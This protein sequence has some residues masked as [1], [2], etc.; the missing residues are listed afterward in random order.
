[1]TKFKG[2]YGIICLAL[3]SLLATGCPLTET[4]QAAIDDAV[5]TPPEHEAPDTE[6]ANPPENCFGISHYQ[7]KAEITKE[8]DI[9]FM[10]DTSGSL[11]AERR[12]IGDGVDAFV[13]ALPADA[14]V[15][16]AVMMA[17]AGNW[18]GKLYQYRDVGP[19]VLNTKTMNLSDIRTI[20]R[21]RMEKV[22][23][24][25][26][27]DGG[28]VGL[29][30]LSRALDEDRLAEAKNLGFFRDQAALAVVF[31]ADEND[32]CARYP[33]GITP[34]YDPDRKEVPAFNKYCQ[35]L[36]PEKVYLK[37]RD[38]Q[39]GRPLLVS[40]IVYSEESV[41]PASGENEI[42]YGILDIVR[43][44]NGLLVDLAGGRIYEGL[45]RIGSLVTKRLNLVT[46]YSL[47]DKGREIDDSTIRVEVDGQ[48]VPFAFQ[49]EVSEV[50]LTDYAGLENSEVYLQYCLKP[51]E[52]HET[53]PVT[54]TKVKV[55]KITSTSAEVTWTTDL[56]S[57]SQVEITESLTGRRW[58][59]PLDSVGVI[60]HMVQ[61][62]GL[63]SDRLYSIRVFSAIEGDPSVSEPIVFRTLR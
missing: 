30:S 25:N 27:T 12:A 5:G 2:F 46:E 15:R 28:E 20:L 48:A 58:T 23:T 39:N 44:N 7:P 18:S 9:L 56:F 40:G 13:G 14:D 16:I 50:H 38:Y 53:I 4:E 17:H 35:D 63:S 31:V 29:Y 59:T 10:V 61:L 47:D 33:E 45:G 11:D 55:D 8:I 51:S 6:R 26:E 62:T 41:F 52:N 19:Y 37:L 22:V 34:V 57:S 24:E 36:T 43:A 42:A 21:Q 1:M 32:I 49:C 3:I 54:I 60:N